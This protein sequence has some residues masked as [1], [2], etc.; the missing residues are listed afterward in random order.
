MYIHTPCTQKKYRVTKKTA[1]L[2]D[3]HLCDQCTQLEQ[4][5]LI[6]R[7]TCHAVLLIVVITYLGLV[8]GLGYLMLGFNVLC[9]K[10]STVSYTE[11]KKY[12][13]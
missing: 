2:F 7:K 6:L 11:D 8:N 5:Q 4:K 10:I 12:W 13:H 3:K 1:L 9:L